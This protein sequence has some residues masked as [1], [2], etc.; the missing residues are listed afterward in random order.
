MSM[1]SDDVFED[2]HSHCSSASVVGMWHLFFVV[3]PSYQYYNCYIG[4]DAA[5]EMVSQYVRV[6]DL[7]ELYSSVSQHCPVCLMDLDRSS[8]VIVAL[9]RCNHMLHLDCLNEML[10][11]QQA[12]KPKVNFHHCKFCN[13]IQ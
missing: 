9:V 11:R 5:S 8:N 4:V 1:G 2:V 12:S 3:D 6:V 7:T 10:R 13:V